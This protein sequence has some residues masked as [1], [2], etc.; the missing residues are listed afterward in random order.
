M[1]VY[2]LK[3]VIKKTKPPVWKRCMIP[4]GITFAQL[5]ILLDEMM[6]QGD[7]DRYEFEFYQ[8][9]VHIREWR[10]GE[11]QV[12]KFNF[13]FM[14]AP[15]TYIDDLFRKEDKF[16]FRIEDGDL[17]RWMDMESL[18]C[19]L[20]ERFATSSGEPDYRSHKELKAGMDGGETGLQCAENPVSRTE[21]NAKSTNTMLKDFADMLRYV[22]LEN[23]SED[24]R[25]QLYDLIDDDTSGEDAD[26]GQ[27]RKMLQNMEQ[28]EGNGAVRM[29]QESPVTELPSRNP[30][31][32]EGLL[33]LTV[34]ELRELAEREGVARYKSLKKDELAEK[35]KNQILLPT[36]MKKRLLILSEDE[37][38]A[39]ENAIE[40]G[41]VMLLTNGN[42]NCWRSFMT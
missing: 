22:L 9:Q 41:D 33:E 15:D 12:R 31:I 24:L 36:V 30:T 8:T 16:T 14:C 3:I 18:N 26:V 39:F 34:N 6:E 11:R 38:S 20:Q 1:N 5:S 2:Q 23:G 25:S 35:I 32:K 42:W 10:E 13:D 19:K 7:S 27:M 4:G 29:K 17:Y 28:S 37:I 21:R 40:K